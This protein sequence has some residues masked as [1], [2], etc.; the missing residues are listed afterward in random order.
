MQRMCKLGDKDIERTILYALKFG[1]SVLL[2]CNLTCE[3]CCVIRGFNLLTCS[4]YITFPCCEYEIPSCV[5]THRTCRMKYLSPSVYYNLLTKLLY[6][7]DLLTKNMY[8]LD[9]LQEKL[10]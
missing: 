5:H 6:I 2:M 3:E 7:D 4:C 1:Y 8:D 10:Y 9:R